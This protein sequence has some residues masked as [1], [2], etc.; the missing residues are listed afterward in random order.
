MPASP[1]LTTLK[2]NIKT[3]VKKAILPGDP[4]AVDKIVHTRRRFWRDLDKFKSLFRR[5]DAGFVDVINGWQIWRNRT[6]PVETPER[7]R[8][9]QLHTFTL[10]GYAGVQDEGVFTQND[11]DNQVEAI[12]DE[13]RL[14][15]TIFNNMERTIADVEVVSFGDAILLGDFTCWRAQL[16]LTCEA[17]ET[18]TE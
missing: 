6:R 18:K 3:E 10:E 8:F 4:A 13:L 2:A 17:I 14:D 16:Q 1:T 7:W 12:R 11:F 9:Y 5:S 15:R